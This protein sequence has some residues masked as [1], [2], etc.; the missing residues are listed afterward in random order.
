MKS[1]ICVIVG[2]GPGLGMA[3][4]RRFADE[5][6]RLALLARNEERLEDFAATLALEGVEAHSFPV[7]AA[8]PQAIASTFDA[9]RTHLGIPDVLIY[10]VYSPRQATPS[11]LAV[12][13]LIDDFRVNVA[14]ALACAQQ[15][16]DALREKDRTGTIIFSS[17][18][19]ALYPRAAYAS[20][21]ASKAALRSLAFTLAEEL[22]PDDIHV[23][24]VT[25]AGSIQPGTH[26]D[27]D[28][29][30]EVYWQ[31]H[32]QSKDNWQTEIVYAKE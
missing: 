25:I 17:G 12:D 6:Y 22:A 19:L 4:A 3:L 28:K 1:S 13:D 29:I 30:A 11:A 23:A 31:L 7:D 5:G 24:V 10:N 14:G 26:F 18:G 2:V 8:D 32:T 15:I 16:I 21:A 27:P 9:I 20:L